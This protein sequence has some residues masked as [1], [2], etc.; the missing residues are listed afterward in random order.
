MG[1]SRHRPEP[2][3]GGRF[4]SDVIAKRIERLRALAG[5]EPKDAGEVLFPH[6]K[7]ENAL[8]SW[9][10]LT[11]WRG[12]DFTLGQIEVVL[13]YFIPLA[14]KRGEIAAPDLPGFP[15]IDIE[16]AVRVWRGQ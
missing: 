15:L 7:P 3:R 2:K 6:Q 5:V 12:A 9:Y 14:F 11:T 16:P 1:P 13:D 4:D 8:R 10:R